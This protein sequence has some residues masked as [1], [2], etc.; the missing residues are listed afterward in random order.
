MNYFNDNTLLN[1][2]EYINGKKMEI[3]KN[4]MI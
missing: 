4:I 1:E 3:G 2:G